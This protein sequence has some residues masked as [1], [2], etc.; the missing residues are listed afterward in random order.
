MASDRIHAIT[1]PRWGMTMTEGTVA[2]WLVAEGATVAA[3]QE[4]L[5]IETTKITNVM[6]SSAGGVLRRRVVEEGATAPVG[7]LLGV[8]AGP[9]VDE[10]DVQSFVAAFREHE[11]E[12]EAEAAPGTAPRVVEAG[13]HR[14]NVL[15]VGSGE[16]A[17]VVLLHGFGGDMDA[18]AFNQ[19]ALGE[20]RVVHALDLP[21]HGGSSPG[22]SGDIGNLAAA[23]TA[24][25]D[26][27]GVERA[28][29]VAHSLGGAV[30]LRI[31]RDSPERIASLA[32]IAPVGLGVEIDA[33]YVDGFLAAERRKAM[34]E[35]L[36][37]LYA[38]P[39]RISSDMVET[40][41]RFKRLDGVPDALRA[42]ADGFVREGRQ[43]VDLRSVLASLDVPT[44]VLWGEDDGIIPARHADGLPA[45]VRVERIPGAGHMPQVEE[46]AAVNRLLAEHVT[47]AEARG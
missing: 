19:E 29:L 40:V 25:L 42:V 5:E 30:A 4:V 2:G 20:G 27:L 22:T 11:A 24:A 37:K 47:A 7:A 35:V 6:E 9:E 36:A 17:P 43:S 23:I 44:L 15:S 10:A 34:K 26:T 12:I 18:W 31:A 1:M 28:H 38:D 32:L 46:A 21:A 33:S 45:S 8:L 3:G 14:I 41:L 16:G 13:P 39:E